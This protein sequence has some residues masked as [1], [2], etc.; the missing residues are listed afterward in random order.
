MNGLAHQSPHGSAS[1]IGASPQRA[2]RLVRG[3]R[4]CEQGGDLIG[5]GRQKFSLVHYLDWWMKEQMRGCDWLEVRS[6][7]CFAIGG[8]LIICLKFPSSDANS[9]GKQNKER[10]HVFIAQT[11]RRFLVAHRAR[12]CPDDPTRTNLRGVFLAGSFCCVVVVSMYE[13]AG[14]EPMAASGALLIA[15]LAIE[16]K[17]TS[18]SVP[19]GMFADAAAELHV[20]KAVD[21]VACIGGDRGV[22]DMTPSSSVE[23]VISTMFGSD[24]YNFSWRD[25]CKA[26]A[27][28]DKYGVC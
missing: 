23:A 11:I 12:R 4:Q 7:C 8:L 25:E 2:A 27:D 26:T 22:K 1:L 16:G 6:A 15:T 9:A 17:L 10:T 3:Q 18:S 28:W 20:E 21:A 24:M 19:R 14:G 5:A 13:K